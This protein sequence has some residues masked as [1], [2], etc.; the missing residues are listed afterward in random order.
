MMLRFFFAIAVTGL[1]AACVPSG[2]GSQ[3]S[4]DGQPRL[5]DPVLACPGQLSR[6]Q[7]I[8]I[9]I[10]NSSADSTTDQIRPRCR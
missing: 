9:R 2:T 10:N 7:R 6:A 8:A 5:N 4:L 1:V 3:S